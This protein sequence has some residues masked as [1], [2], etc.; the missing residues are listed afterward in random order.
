VSLRGTE[1]VPVAEDNTAVRLFTRRAFERYRCTVLETGGVDAIEVV[2][3]HGGGIA[4][5]IVLGRVLVADG[6]PPEAV[7]RR[8]AR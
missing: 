3:A 8:A 7:C 5:A 6:L 1:T 2:M 4:Y